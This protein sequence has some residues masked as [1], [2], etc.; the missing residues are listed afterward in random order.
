M[1]NLRQQDTYFAR[2]AAQC[3]AA[4][5]AATVAEIK[6]A[7]LDLAQGWRHLVPEA[8]HGTTAPQIDPL[9]AKVK[10]R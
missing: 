7:Y 8:T 3:A 9:T 1:P 6:E 5:S 10:R 2:Q 4:A